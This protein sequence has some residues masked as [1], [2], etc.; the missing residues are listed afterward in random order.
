MTSCHL[1]LFVIYNVHVP[2]LY[3]FCWDNSKI[4]KCIYFF[5]KPV[6]GDPD[7]SPTRLIEACLQEKYV[8]CQKEILLYYKKNYIIFMILIFVKLVLDKREHYDSQTGTRRLLRRHLIGNPI[9][10]YRCIVK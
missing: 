2:F 7:C 5:R 10:F 1:I 4:T 9:K 6:T 3:I 8:D